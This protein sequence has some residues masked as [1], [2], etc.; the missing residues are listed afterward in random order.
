MTVV[1]HGGGKPDQLERHRHAL[2]ALHFEPRGQQR[3]AREVR[4]QPVEV[5]DILLL[6][7]PA[8]APAPDPEMNRL[9]ARHVER[10]A[11]EPTETARAEEVPVE[12]LAREFL[13]REEVEIG[14]EAELRTP[15]PRVVRV[16]TMV[17]ANGR[18]SSISQFAAA[19]PI[20][21][22]VWSRTEWKLAESDS[23]KRAMSSRTAGQ[24][25]EMAAAS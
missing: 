19:V 25:S 9:A 1:E 13:R 7:R 18:N 14:Q 5:G 21:R 24:N 3:R 20:A 15:R 16:L 12:R 8:H 22:T 10:R 11:G 4:P 6:E 2:C 23:V 17:C